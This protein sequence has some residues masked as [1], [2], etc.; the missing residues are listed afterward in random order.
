MGKVSEFYNGKNIFISG[1]TGFL[2]KVLLFKLLTEFQDL[3]KVYVLIRGKRNG[4][5][6][7]DRKMC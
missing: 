7:K 4:G 1:A 3:S 2:G 6:I 5:C